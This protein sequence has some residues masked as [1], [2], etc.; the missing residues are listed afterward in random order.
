MSPSHPGGTT[1]TGGSGP[2]PGTAA[3]AAADAAAAGP[4]ARPW[5]ALWALCLGFFMILVDSTI[6]SVAT[7]ALMRGLG[8][9]VNEVVWVTS[10]YLLAY[11]VPLLITGRL[12]DRFGPKNLYLAGLTVF[13]VSSAWC[14]LTS[15]IEPLV[16][17]RVFQGLGA[18]MMSPQTMAVITRVFPATKRGQAMG[19][20]GAVAGVATLVGPVLGGVLVD[21]L[22]W[23]WIF[24]VNVPVGVVGL[25]LAWRLVPT[26]PTHSHS[27]DL[28]GV[29]L[30]GVGMF[31]V[32][33][34]IQEGR[35]YDWGTVVGPVTVWG[36]IGTGV[37][38]LALFVL[39][40]ARNRR[41]PLVPL[42][43]FGDRNFS[44]ANLAITTVGFAITAMTF[45]LMLY[46][47][48][49]R[50]MSPTE[51]ALLLAPMAVISGVLA[52]FVGRLVDRVH[53][54]YVAGVGL[55][56]FPV[57]LVW[58]SA[59]MSPGS[60]TWQLLLP[61]AL[62][63][64]ANGFMWSPMSTTATRNLPMRYA[65]AGAGVYNTTRQVGAVLGSASIAALMSSR[66]DA[67]LPGGG[68]APVAGE[69]ASAGQQLPAALHEGFASAMA[70]S[71]LLPAAVLVVGWVA[72]LCFATPRHLR[73]DPGNDTAG[74]EASEDVP[75]G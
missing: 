74:R 63:G 58:L 55:L 73:A 30:S 51:A 34:G 41:E 3:A 52:P 31:C 14:G 4:H 66:L 11:A 47:Q 29:A 12:G 46:A 48:T 35:T 1:S 25:V 26:L 16:V 64:V 60:A 36:L 20:W 13:T 67:L 75:A 44:L 57:A 68:G 37:A 18:A 39:W 24:F 50:G 71:M 70:Q 28:V 23:E 49:V 2:L 38:V 27:F 21:S 6:V 59:V 40:Q 65:G 17:A 33:F 15:S 19:A 22:G 45:P 43:L 54:R 56:A 72:V 9:G 32:V 7:P 61:V 5:A 42:S 69:G 10:A 8:A 53:P 62:L